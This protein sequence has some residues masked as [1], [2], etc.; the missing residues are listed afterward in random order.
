MIADEPALAPA[1]GVADG[2]VEL[3]SRLAAGRAGGVTLQEREVVAACS[4]RLV[5]ARAARV[6]LHAEINALADS[7]RAILEAR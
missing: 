7:L 1:L 6:L 4:A 5:A 2:V 3:R